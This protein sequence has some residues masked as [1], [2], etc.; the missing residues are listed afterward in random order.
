M[1]NNRV[2]YGYR[3]MPIS[4]KSSAQVV[5]D[6]LAERIVSEFVIHATKADFSS[7]MDFKTKF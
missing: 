6:K 3:D 5:N 2:V 1:Q 4:N 7:D